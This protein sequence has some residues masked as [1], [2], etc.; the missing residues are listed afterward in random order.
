MWTTVVY[1]QPENGHIVCNVCLDVNIKLRHL[2]DKEID[3]YQ[4]SPP[5]ESKEDA[6]D[7]Y[8]EED[9]YGE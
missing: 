6:E 2:A 9:Y 5:F 1:T 8:E 7:P 3:Y 4:G